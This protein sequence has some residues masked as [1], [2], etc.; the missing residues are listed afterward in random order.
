MLAGAAVC[1][2]RV[3]DALW[4][5]GSAYADLLTIGRVRAAAGMTRYFQERKNPGVVTDSKIR[6]G[7]PGDSATDY[8]PLCPIV[9]F[10]D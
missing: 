1:C 4:T 9:N 6:I 7:H 5:P 2:L 3:N 8:T 10:K